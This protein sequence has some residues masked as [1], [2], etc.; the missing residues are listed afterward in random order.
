[1]DLEIATGPLVVA[2]CTEPFGSA[3]RIPI[4]RQDHRVRI[5]HLWRS[6][7]DDGFG[8]NYDYLVELWK[9]SRPPSTTVIVEGPDP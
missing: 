9:G 2:G 5:T 6:T 8:D 7:N 4:H 1:M 3:A